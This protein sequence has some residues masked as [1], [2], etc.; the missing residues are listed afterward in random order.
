MPSFHGSM[1]EFRRSRPPDLV[2]CWPNSGGY[3]RR[4]RASLRCLQCAGAICFVNREAAARSILAWSTSFITQLFWP[5]GAS[6]T[7]ADT[8]NCTRSWLA[9]FLVLGGNTHKKV[10][11]APR[12]RGEK[13]KTR[14]PDD[15]SAPVAPWKMPVRTRAS[16]SRS[17]G[18]HAGE[19]GFCFRGCSS[20]KACRAVFTGN[21]RI[22]SANVM[23][24]RTLQTSFVMWEN[25]RMQI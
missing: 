21:N 15:K 12:V 6:R 4:N 7:P 20:G 13:L 17:T 10:D 22:Q 25:R 24:Y 18:P 9:R 11:L 1:D 23:S 3:S 8:P 2:L 5:S 14:R 19:L 16:E